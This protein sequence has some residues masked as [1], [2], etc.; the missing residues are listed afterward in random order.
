MQ[1]QP[2]RTEG[3]SKELWALSRYLFNGLLGEVNLAREEGAAPEE[4]KRVGI[5]VVPDGVALRLDAPQ[6]LWTALD[7]LAADEE[8]G[9]HIMAAQNVEN[10][11]RIARAGAVVE[12][13]GDSISSRGPTQKSRPKKLQGGNTP[14]VNIQ[15]K[16]AEE[17]Y[18]AN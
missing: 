10:L 8:C 14:G 17:A 7:V 4:R 2:T 6:N 9:F 11:P 18:S 12:G 15:A 3:R 13:K 1:A 16:Q 5:G